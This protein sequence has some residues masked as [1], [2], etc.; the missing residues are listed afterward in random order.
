MRFF[1]DS[2]PDERLLREERIHP[3]IFAYPVILGIAELVPALPLLFLFSALSKMASQLSPSN[4]TPGFGALWVLLGML[5]FLPTFVVLLVVLLAYANSEILLTNK[6][7][8]YR[9]GFL[10]RAAGELPLDNVDA[11]FIQEPLLGRLFGFGT[12][13]VSSVGGAQFPFRFIGRPQV[14]H[15]MLQRAVADARKPRRADP[16]MVVQD[17]SRYMPKG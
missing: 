16:A 1:F 13:A 10:A 15:A 8:I 9:T 11:M 12:V 17:D 14:F 5:L 6:R 4:S 2:E 3:G 7:L